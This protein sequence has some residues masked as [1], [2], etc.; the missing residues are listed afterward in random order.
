MEAIEHES[1]EKNIKKIYANVSIT[2]KSF[3]ESKGFKVV[4][5]KNVVKKGCL[6]NIF[7]MEKYYF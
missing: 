1:K 2:A 4:K 5:Q 7:L 6:L 3:F